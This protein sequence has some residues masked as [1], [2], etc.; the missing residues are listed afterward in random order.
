MPDARLQACLPGGAGIPRSLP[1]MEL[2]KAPGCVSLPLQSWPNGGRAGHVHSGLLPE[3][4]P[5]AQAPRPR[6]FNTPRAEPYDPFPK[7]KAQ[8]AATSGS[9]NGGLQ[10]QVFGAHSACHCKRWFP[11]SYHCLSLDAVFKCPL[12]M[13]LAELVDRAAN[14]EADDPRSAGSA[15]VLRGAAQLSREI[16]T[17]NGQPKAAS[18]PPLGQAMRE[19]A[20]QEG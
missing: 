13:P 16:M 10:R 12:C 4:F 11:G 9:G 3:V 2:P 19:A 8:T 17:E 14:M 5:Y 6:S 7:A 15:E 18:V 20:A 1:A